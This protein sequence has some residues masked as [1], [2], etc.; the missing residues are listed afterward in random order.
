MP[1][2]S[3]HMAVT[4]PPY[5]GLRSYEVSPTIWGGIPDCDHKWGAEIPAKYV[6]HWETFS[7]KDG[8]PM[9]ASKGWKDKVKKT[10]QKN[11]GSFCLKCGAWKGCLG[12]EPNMEMYIKHLNQIFAE[13][14]RVLRKDGTFWLN[15]GDSY[16]GS[17]FQVENLQSGKNDNS[18]SIFYKRRGVGLKTK[19]QCLI[20]H[21]IALT[22][23]GYAV[24]YA[25]ELWKLTE[26][27]QRAREKNNWD[28][29]VW[30]EEVLRRWAL[31]IKIADS[32]GWWVRSTIIWEKNNSLPSNANDRPANNFEY[33]FLLS[34]SKHY[35]YDAE[36]I[37]EPQ[38]EISIKR[39]F[40]TN[41]L[42]RRKDFGKKV[43]GYSSESQNKAL[44]KLAESVRNGKPALRHKRC[45]WTIPTNGFKEAHFATFPSPLIRPIILAGSSPKV[46]SACGAPWKR[47]KEDN[48]GFSWRPSCDCNAVTTKAIVLDPF[49]G[50]GTTA[51]VATELGRDFIGIE[52]GEKY[53]EMANRRL[54]KINFQLPL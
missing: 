6:S 22:L 14:K 36:A 10:K 49:M 38:K 13:V 18:K 4:S 5:F 11:H 54:Q 48:N 20:P 21:R 24:V 17:G 50:A 35:Y 43:Y 40:A 41:H 2:E 28:A 23:Q 3:I 26:A 33:V 37:K 27:L 25:D 9:D 7:W 46:C 8:R 32:S 19:D 30:V 44:T 42:E 29:V 12:Q 53:I 34:K 16:A 15:I 51:L 45:V 31:A 39:A 52:I 1:D 47:I